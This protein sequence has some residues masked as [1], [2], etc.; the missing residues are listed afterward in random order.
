[1]NLVVAVI[2]KVRARGS[3]RVIVR[4]MVRVSVRVQGQGEG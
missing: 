1:M 3:V 4:V 2:G